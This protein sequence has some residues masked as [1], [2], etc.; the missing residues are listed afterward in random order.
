MVGKL[1]L[2]PFSYYFLQMNYRQSMFCFSLA[3]A[4]GFYALI[5]GTVARE[6]GVFGNSMFATCVILTLITNIASG[7]LCRHFLPPDAPFGLSWSRKAKS[8][9]GPPEPK[10][11]MSSV[12]AAKEPA[13]PAAAGG[14]EADAVA[15]RV[16]A[17]GSPQP[18]DMSVAQPSAA[19]PDLLSQEL[20]KRGASDSAVADSGEEEEEK[21]ES[22]RAQAKQ[23]QQKRERRMRRGLSDPEFIR[24][25]SETQDLEAVERALVQEIERAEPE[26]PLYMPRP[27]MADHDEEFDVHFCVFPEDL[28]LPMRAGVTRLER[29]LGGVVAKDLFVGSAAVDWL[30]ATQHYPTRAFAAEICQRLL[31]RGFITHFGAAERFIDG[32][33]VYRFVQSKLPAAAELPASRASMSFRAPRRRSERNNSSRNKG[34]ATK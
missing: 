14:A 23:G 17:A 30:M 27:F 24:S 2:I 20:P 15:V 21:T 28:V 1:A 16:A 18:D 10:L 25:L 31:E 6:L 4:R 22:M 5:T 33:R 19:S 11:E 32:P 9:A 13:A 3:N 34:E 29:E 7:P 12:D 8:L 26:E